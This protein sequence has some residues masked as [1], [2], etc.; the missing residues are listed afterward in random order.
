MGKKS[1]VIIW[2]AVMAA[3]AVAAWMMI[4]AA[5]GPAQPV[6]EG[7]PLGFWLVQLNPGEKYEQKQHDEAVVAVQQMGTNAVPFLLRLLRARDSEFKSFLEEFDIPGIHFTLAT[8]LNYRALLGFEALGPKGAGAVPDLIALLREDWSDEHAYDTE[9]VLGYIGPA[10]KAAVP[11]LVQNAG[12][13]NGTLRGGAIMALGGIH[14]DP[15]LSVPVLAKELRDTNWPS[16]LNA[17]WALGRFGPD[18]EQAVPTLVE[19]IEASTNHPPTTNAYRMDRRA[20]Q[21][22]LKQIDPET[23][24]RVVTNGAAGN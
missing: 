4:R 23:Y 14:S 15:G 21:N 10:A 17:A 24:A 8:D 12:S 18:A 6:Y 22:A 9:Y 7:K 2:P 1:R 5:A 3:V 19:L 13:T 11:L 20:W 16:T